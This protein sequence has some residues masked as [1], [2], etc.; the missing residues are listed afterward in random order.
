MFLCSLCYCFVRS[1]AHFL[2]AFFAVVLLLL[3]LSLFWNY[4]DTRVVFPV[5][6]KCL[7]HHYLYVEQTCCRQYCKYFLLA[8]FIIDNDLILVCFKIHFFLFT[9]SI[10]LLLLYCIILYCIVRV[11]RFIHS[12][13][14]IWLMIAMFVVFFFFCCLY[15]RYIYVVTVVVVKLCTSNK[16]KVLSE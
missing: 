1:C 14:L 7:F 15:Y 12:L 16:L 10:S 13:F 6:V 5:V 8:K 11:F 9:F 4:Y 2:F 3:V